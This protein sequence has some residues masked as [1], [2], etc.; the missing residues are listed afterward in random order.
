MSHRVFITAAVAA[1]ILAPA[2]AQALP[3]GSARAL[4]TKHAEYTGTPDGLV[5][6][7]RAEPARTPAPASSAAPGTTYPP[8][9]DVTYRRGALYHEIWHGE[10][11]AP[12][13]ASTGARSGRRTRTATP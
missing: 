6:T 7:Y 8:A 4:L 10:G 9:E 11:V 2:A 13:P 5:V 12:R 1:L 3:G